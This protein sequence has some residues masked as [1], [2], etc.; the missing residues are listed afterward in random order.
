MITLSVIAAGVCIT[1]NLIKRTAMKGSHNSWTYLRPR[2]LWMYLI[3]WTARCQRYSIPEQYVDDTKCFD[4]RVKFDKRGNMTIAHGLVKYK[5][6]D[7]QL[8]QD[9][10]WLSAVSTRQFPVYVRV[11]HEVR[12]K[13]ELNHSS[14]MCFRRF[15]DNLVKRFPGITFFGGNNLVDGSVDYNFGNCVTIEDAYASVVCP[16]VGWWPWLY[17]RFN[18]K[19]NLSKKTDKDVVFVD[20]VDIE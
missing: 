8:M 15:C 11:L 4:L 20:F 3:A 5:Y 17:A 2:R 19:K 14:Q 10:Q 12:N 13:R 1:R 9:L 6:T 18:N 7:T 16:K